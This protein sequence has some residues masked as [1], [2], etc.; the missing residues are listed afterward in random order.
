MRPRCDERWAV[1]IVV[2][3]G[4]GFLGT[5]LV[6]ALRA[7]QHDVVV[8]TRGG[9]RAEGEVAW[10]PDQPTGPWTAL[11]GTADAVVNLA[12]ESLAAGRWTAA[13]KDLIRRSRL[14]ATRALA[15]A[16]GAAARPPVFLSASGVGVYGLRGDEPVGEEGDGGRD[17]LATVC[18]EWEEAARQAATR[19][20]LL[21][22]GVVLAEH[23]GALPELA[24][25]FRFFAGGPIG[26]GRQYISWIHRD[27]WVA[28]VEWAL[29]RKDL[30]GPLNVTA[31]HP[32]TN[33]EFAR[34]LGAAL[35]RPSWLRTPAWP[36][37]L[38]L[39][40]MADAAI[41]GGQR[42]VPARALALGFTFTYPALHQALAAIYG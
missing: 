12:G 27:D 21:R 16:I 15:V 36:V 38:A 11:L 39:G 34:H 32:V 31:P 26:S 4:S 22:S 2:A 20:V 18:R 28:L 19:V 10:S 7:R 5:A 23:G 35:H 3:G 17:F 9:A 40:E 6:S 37:R 24:R 33:A 29:T 13:R 14:A 42:V 1:R 30:A 41:L 25:P 8:L